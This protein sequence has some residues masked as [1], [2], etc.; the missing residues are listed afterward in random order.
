MYGSEESQGTSKPAV[1]PLVAGR[2]HIHVG[3][4]GFF[5]FFQRSESVEVLV[6]IS[7]EEL[8]RVKDQEKS[9]SRSRLE[10]IA[11]IRNIRIHE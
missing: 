1:F 6:I 8:Q 7:L 9:G 3:R 10:R 2:L 5:F 11:V 4:I